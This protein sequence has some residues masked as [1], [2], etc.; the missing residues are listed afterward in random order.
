MEVRFGLKENWQQFSLLVLV[1]AFVGGMVGLERSILP[2]LAAQEF[3]IA[4]NSAIFSF[5][6]VFG[7]VK[8]LTNYFAG[9]FANAL[10]RRRL[11]IF[12][13]L[14]AIPIPFLL[15]WAPTWN[16]IVAANV[17]LGINQG[18]AW[19][20][21]VTMKID[22]VGDKQRGLAM[23]INEFAGYLSVGLVALLTAWIA[24][25]YGIRPYPF[26]IGIV[27]VFLGLLISWIWV[28]D[29]RSFVQKAAQE[30]SL[31]LL[32]KPFWDTSLLHR[33]LGA[34]SQAGLVN[35]LN[36]GMI[37]GLFPL[38]LASKGFDLG[39]IGIITA[40]YPLVWG[41]AQLGTGR[42]SDFIC[43]KD[44]L[45]IG[46]LLQA[47]A[48][49]GLIWAQ[50]FAAFAILSFVIGVGTAIVYPTFLASI[51][52]NTHPADRAASLGTFRLWRDLGYA[53]GAILTGILSDYF[54]LE[55][56]VIVIGLLTLGS[57]G[58]IKW[59]MIC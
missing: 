57:A 46:M 51:A 4:S 37:W 26:Y 2:Q 49:L 16:W 52:E 11:L 42:L 32:K 8:A 50:T 9:H 33:N 1:N 31:P 30:S 10:G 17:L 20:S 27:F 5:I 40:I 14:F 41:L 39:Q 34:I 36:D 23:G 56:S 29:T 55:V 38:L 54:E 18:L 13:W 6:V 44:L 28:K 59:R 21:T 15:M 43:Q 58:V 53:F 19:S 24:N 7:I 25:T 3:H 35:N 48:I 45:F 12:G 47:F 22:L